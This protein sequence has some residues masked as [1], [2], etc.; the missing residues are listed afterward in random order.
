MVIIELIYKQP[1]EIVDKYVKEHREFLQKN[2]DAGHLVV[3]GPKNPRVGGIIVAK[4]DKETV[5]AFMK[6][7]PFYVNNIADYNFTEFQS[8]LY[9][10][11]LDAY[12]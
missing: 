12:L 5:E 8:V 3:S 6:Q 9:C 4:G 2:Y 10:K 11:E 7:D 1:L